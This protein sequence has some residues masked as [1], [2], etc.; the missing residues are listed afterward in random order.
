MQFYFILIAIIIILNKNTA[1][2]QNM[3]TIVCSD[4]RQF[5][6]AHV[7]VLNI[8]FIR[9]DMSRVKQGF[10]VNDSEDTSIQ[11]LGFQAQSKLNHIPQGLKEQF[12]NLIGLYFDDAP[13]KMLTEENMEQFGSDL[14]HFHVFNSLITYL[15]RKTF[16]HNSNL[17]FLSLENNPLKLIESGFFEVISKMDDLIYFDMRQC[18]C[19]NQFKENIEIKKAKWTHSCG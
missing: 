13:L 8:C 10:I 7:G 9:T 18:Q 4:V 19:I 17:K 15:S 16:I 1:K 12:P 14:I 5:Y 6:W 2:C 11:G 3:V